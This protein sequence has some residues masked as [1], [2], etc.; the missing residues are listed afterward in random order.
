MD[1]AGAAVC[2][3]CGEPAGLDGDFCLLCGELFCRRHLSVRDGVSNCTDCEKERAAIES[4]S[5][6]SR[7]HRDG[8]MAR[9]DR[10]MRSTIEAEYQAIAIEAAARIL[11]FADEVADYQQRVVDD[12]QQSIHDAFVDTAWPACPIHGNH[13]LWFS[14]GWWR[15]PQAGPVARLGEL[16][17]VK[18]QTP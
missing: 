11:L 5:P 13:P 18:R 16:P 15:C 2:S 7:D 9:L 1:V 10:D 14:E 8:V 3:V 12:V 17:P 4:A 6:V